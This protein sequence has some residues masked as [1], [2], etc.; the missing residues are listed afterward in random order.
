M[1][2]K[3]QLMRTAKRINGIFAFVLILV[4]QLLF[5]NGSSHAQ[6]ATSQS[7]AMKKQ[8]IISGRI[9]SPTRVEIKLA[10]PLQKIDPNDFS[11]E[12][13]IDIKNIQ[14]LDSTRLVLTT[15]PLDVRQ[16]YRLKTTKLGSKALL[17][18]AFRSILFE[19]PLGCQREG[20]DWPSAFSRRALHQNSS[21]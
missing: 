9:Q 20:S 8:K 5:S 19:K 6:S 14:A 17:H 10:R 7:D 21:F 18:D 15:P 2:M 1:A 11:I 3:T 12:P 4:L 16:N 13:A